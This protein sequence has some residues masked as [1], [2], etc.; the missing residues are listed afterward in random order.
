MFVKIINFKQ[1]FQS[2]KIETCRHW[3]SPI[4]S[5]DIKGYLLITDTI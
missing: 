3:D 5:H 2:G 4:L 1:M